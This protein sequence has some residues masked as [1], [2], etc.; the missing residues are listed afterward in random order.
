MKRLSYL[1]FKE[2]TLD[3]KLKTLIDE[4][5]WQENYKNLNTK[6]PVI[7]EKQHLTEKSVK[8]YLKNLDCKICSAKKP[9]RFIS[10]E[11]F[12]KKA[13]PEYRYSFADDLKD[14]LNYNDEVNVTCSVHGIQRRTVK[15][16]L[17]QS[18]CPECGNLSINKTRKLTFNKFKEKTLDNKLKTLIDEDWWQEN[19]KNLN[20]KIP[21]ICE[22][23]GEILQPVSSYLKN[24]KCKECHD[25]SNRIDWSKRLSFDNYYSQGQIITEDYTIPQNTYIEIPCSKCKK[26][27]QKTIFM[28]YY[29]QD[30][31]CINCKKKE[32]GSSYER[33]IIE[34][35]EENKIKYISEYFI[36]HQGQKLFFDFY[37]PNKNIF[38]EVDGEQHFKPVE[39][40]GGIDAFKE[41]KKRD[42]LKNRYCFEINSKLIRIPFFDMENYKEYLKKYKI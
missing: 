26:I 21:V 20:T 33:K 32:K 16:I 1:E 12:L 7:C 25:E 4:D 10:K 27:M 3:N 41:L 8:T 19:Y 35:L 29:Q 24:L 6:I 14:K 38:I 2:K 40:F 31:V 17:H 37:I 5:W 42:F 18:S 34:H 39:Y 9:K 30:H 22:K 23:H 36:I 11:T 28:M 15:E 13:N